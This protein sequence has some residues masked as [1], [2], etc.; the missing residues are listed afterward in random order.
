MRNKN[1]TNKKIN[2]KPSE[3]FPLIGIQ[4]PL[5][6]LGLDIIMQEEIPTMMPKWI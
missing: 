5:I 3:L 4:H 2:K 6:C 1:K